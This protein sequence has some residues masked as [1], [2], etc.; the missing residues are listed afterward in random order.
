[1]EPSASLACL[2]CRDIVESASVTSPV[3]DP[4]M[5]R[6]SFP[7][8]VGMARGHPGR[9]TSPTYKL[10]L[11]AVSNLAVNVCCEVFKTFAHIVEEMN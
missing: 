9:F 11:A 8:F 4:I 7:P 5:P 10:R 6:H 1:M 3:R 2:A